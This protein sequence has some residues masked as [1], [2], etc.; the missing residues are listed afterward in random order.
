MENQAVEQLETHTVA[1]A[2][3]H[4]HFFESEDEKLYKANKLKL[5]DMWTNGAMETTSQYLSIKHPQT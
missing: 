2:K 4:A 5:D 1:K 3:S